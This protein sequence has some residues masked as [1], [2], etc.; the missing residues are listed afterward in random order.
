MPVSL[1]DLRDLL[2]LEELKRCQKFEWKKIRD[3]N[4]DMVECLTENCD[5]FFYKGTGDEQLVF[6]FCPSCGV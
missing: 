6:H 2:S 3:Q 5:Y 1:P 4:P